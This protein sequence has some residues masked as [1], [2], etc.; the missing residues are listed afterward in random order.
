[1]GEIR[2]ALS[3]EVLRVR[4]LQDMGDTVLLGSVGRFSTVLPLWRRGLVFS[5]LSLVPW[6]NAFLKIPSTELHTL[7]LL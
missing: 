2:N 4:G 5:L 6:A 7:K 1:M 3:G